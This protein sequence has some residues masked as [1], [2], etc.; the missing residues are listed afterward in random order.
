MADRFLSDRH[1]GNNEAA[2]SELTQ[3]FREHLNRTQW[4]TAAATKTR[5][6]GDV[7]PKFNGCS[8]EGRAYVCDYTL[9]Y[10]DGFSEDNKLWVVRTAN[11]KWAISGSIVKH[12]R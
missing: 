2:W 6:H 5:Q 10:K 8:F 4:E 12:R 3:P 9:V 11:D 1:S 7:E